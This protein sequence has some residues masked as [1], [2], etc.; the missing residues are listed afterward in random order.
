VEAQGLGFRGGIQHLIKV[1]VVLLKGFKGVIE[2]YCQ[3]ANVCLE[4]LSVREPNR[5]LCHG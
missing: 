3:F 5:I 2:R 4:V 1:P